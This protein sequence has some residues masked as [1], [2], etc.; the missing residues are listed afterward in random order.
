MPYLP[1]HVS[2]RRARAASPLAPVYAR[3]MKAALAWLQLPDV[4]VA[5]DGLGVQVRRQLQARMR[6]QMRIELPQRDERHLRMDVPMDLMSE[7]L[8]LV[9]VAVAEEFTEEF[10]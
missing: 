7:L 4:H 8:D 9:E 5:E 6:H 10:P 3:V 2:S 1:T